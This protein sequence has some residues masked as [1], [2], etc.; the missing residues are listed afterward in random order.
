MHPV[1][2]LSRLFVFL[3]SLAVAGF[4]FT[5][6]FLASEDASI[7]FNR[8]N[9][10]DLGVFFY[11]AG[12][13]SVHPQLVAALVAPLAPIFQALTY[14]G[15]ALAIWCGVFFYM[16]RITRNLPI[17]LCMIA[18]FSIFDQIY[19]INLTYSLWSSLALI[20]LIGLAGTLERRTLSIWESLIAALLAL[21]S[22]LSLFLAPLFVYRSLRWRRDWGGHGVTLMVFMAFVLLPDPDSHRAS[23]MELL[24]R[25]GEAA[26]H[27]TS[28]PKG[29]MLDADHSAILTLRSVSQWMG[30]GVVLIGA[31]LLMAR[32][33]IADRVGFA[34]YVISFLSVFLVS[35]AASEWPLQSRYWFPVL[36]MAGVVLGFVLH[37]LP[38]LVSGMLVGIFLLA[39]LGAHTQRAL[40]W[41]G[42]ARDLSKLMQGH[43]ENTAV[44]RERYGNGPRWAVG[45]G[46]YDFEA[47]DCQDLP[48]HPKAEVQ[49]FR[50][51]CGTPVV[52]PT[53]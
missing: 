41:E 4:W 32:G 9:H 2:P 12:Y 45:L 48:Y 44:L 21:A 35:M 33:R 13:M 43:A 17:T 24:A 31:P 39:A 40:Q 30:L 34:L 10:L 8:Q 25:L 20:G 22:P 36:V 5:T 51:F 18:Y 42:V 38:R 6:N 7:L 47:S 14:A 11:H 3:L 15:V 46:Q 50:I 1:P 19:I 29:F 27:I 52:W 49:N 23:V 28:D 26:R 37:P 16:L 53:F